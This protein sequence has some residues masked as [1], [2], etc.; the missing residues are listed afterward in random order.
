MASSELP[1][2]HS[3][4]LYGPRPTNPVLQYGFLRKARLGVPHRVVDGEPRVEH[5]AGANTASPRPAEE[6]EAGARLGPLGHTEDL[7]TGRASGRDLGRLRS[8]RRW[9]RSAAHQEHADD[10]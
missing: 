4:T 3:P 9:R 1:R 6:G 8:H 10:A 5:E 7:Q 2:V